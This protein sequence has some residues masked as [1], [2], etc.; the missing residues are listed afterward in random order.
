MAGGAA[1]IIG[2]MLNYEA[3]GVTKFVLRPIGEGDADVFDQTQR[4]IEEVIRPVHN[5]RTQPPS[6]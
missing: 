2:R 6:R 4:L 1:D 3:A 5:R